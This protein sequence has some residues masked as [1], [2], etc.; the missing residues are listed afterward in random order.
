MS[1][2]SP[3]TLASKAEGRWGTEAA[4]QPSRRV[5]QGSIKS[6]R[7]GDTSARGRRHPVSHTPEE[8]ALAVVTADP[9]AA[10]SIDR[11]ASDESAASSSWDTLRDRFL[12]VKLAVRC[13]ETL[14]LACGHC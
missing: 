2:F 9:S 8:A 12:G 1:H 14:S 7:P 4:L 10:G 11:R 13:L 3:C 5:A 6:Y